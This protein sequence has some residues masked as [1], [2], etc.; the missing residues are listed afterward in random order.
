MPLYSL[1]LPLLVARIRA[2]N[3][4]DAAASN[5]LAALADSLD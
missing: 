3:P 5:D 4:D 1:T 2:N